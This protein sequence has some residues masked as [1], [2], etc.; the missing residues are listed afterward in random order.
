MAKVRKP[1][2]SEKEKLLLL[3]EWEKRQNI[4]RPKFSSKIT[5][6]GKHNAWQEIADSLNAQFPSVRRDVADLQKKWQNM[7]SKMKEETSRH[8]K[9]SLKTGGGPAPPDLSPLDQRLVTLVGENTPSIIGING[10]F[11]S[12]GLL[13]L[14]EEQPAVVIFFGKKTHATHVGGVP[15]PII[16]QQPRPIQ[17]TTVPRKRRADMNDDEYGKLL[18][19]EQKRSEAETRRAQV[20][21]EKLELE[22]EMLC[23]QI[24][25]LQQQ[26]F[27]NQ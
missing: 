4:L 11:D 6:Q 20:E 12:L 15:E 14:P 24:A 2:F 8:R 21:I 18:V 23:L 5:S 7:N 9:D 25:I 22:K 10:G 26:N 16:S 19:L 17:S 1:N 13:S 27:Q 3:S